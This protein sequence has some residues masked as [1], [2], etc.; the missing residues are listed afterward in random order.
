MERMVCRYLLLVVFCTSLLRAQAPDVKSGT[1]DE[2]K[3][4]QVATKLMGQQHSWD[5][6]AANSATKLIFKEKSRKKTDQ[7]TVITYAVSAPDLPKDRHYSLMGWPLNRE[8]APLRGGITLNA[9]GSL[10]CTGK[11]PA[12]CTPAKTGDDP[13]IDIALQFAKGEPKRFALISDD[14]KSK[15]LATVV[16]FPITSKDAN[17][18]LEALLGTPDAQVMLIT[19]RGFPPSVGVPISSDSA[20]EVSTAV[21][22][23]NDKGELMSMVLP[24]VRGKTSGDT[25]IFLKSP[26]C[27]PKISFHWGKDTYHVE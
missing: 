24:K 3:M 15:A 14:Q 17:C 9:E 7:G 13:V 27:A 11:T 25:T 19:G 1:T 10:L 12:D 18:S 8:I 16:A 5:E 20:G 4:L 6:A 21:W 2:Q 26:A 22:H 23:V